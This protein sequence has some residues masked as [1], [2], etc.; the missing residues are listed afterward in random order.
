[1]TFFSTIRGRLTLLSGT[2]I[3]FCLAV[4]AGAIINLRALQAAMGQMD[5]SAR[6]ASYFETA[7]MMHDALRADVLS[8]LSAATPEEHAVASR[9]VKDHAEK[10]RTSLSETQKVASDP[11]AIHGLEEVGPVIDAYIASAEAIVDKAAKNQVLARADLPGFM[12][13]FIELEGKNEAVSFLLVASVASTRA[14]AAEESTRTQKIMIGVALVAVF[15]LAVLAWIISGRI[16]R[17]LHAIV[18]AANDAA[19]GHVS[20]QVTE[21]G[22]G[23]LRQLADSFNALLG[24]LRE[25]AHGISKTAVTLSSAARELSSVADDISSS[26]QSQA[27][28]LEE[29]AASMEEITATVKQ[30]ADNAHQASQLAASSRDVA[31]KGGRVVGQAVSAMAEI[32]SSSRQIA[33]IITTIDEIAFQTNLLA[34]NAAVEAAR[35]GAQGR[36]FAVVAAEVRSLAGRSASAAKEIKG[37]IGVSSTKVE[38]GSSL[39]N[40]SG[41]TLDEIVVGVKR[42]TDIV[43][44]IAAASR[45]QSQG[46]DEINRAV[47]Q[48]DQITQQNA[49]QTEELSATAGT[50]AAQ[51][52]ELEALVSWFKLGDDAP[53]RAPAETTRSSARPRVTARAT[54][55]GPVRHQ[56]AATA[57]AA[58]RKEAEAELDGFVNY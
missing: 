12:K 43:A 34:L 49:A 13:S 22:E 19:R 4:G 46:I 44:E 18:S 41:A 58:R 38:Q 5:V 20:V 1:M 23:E 33:E 37:L 2:G 32:N 28:S 40:Q 16:T 27:S 35:A 17:P 30:N 53:R 25:T 39:V 15:L 31:G 29:T 26:A 56:P 24:K 10:F 50:L 3:I 57:A 55:S 7:D 8:A 11:E 48:M 9:D 52:S 21:L 51:A 36:G 6:A 42:V 54:S 47:S 45:E 14:Q